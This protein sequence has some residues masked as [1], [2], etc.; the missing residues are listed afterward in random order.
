M[1]N[2]LS[3]GA[4]ASLPSDFDMLLYILSL[5]SFGSDVMYLVGT[6]YN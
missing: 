2:S 1:K 6:K 4:A 3:D 5:T